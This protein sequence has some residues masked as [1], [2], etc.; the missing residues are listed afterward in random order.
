MIHDVRIIPL[1]DRP[2]IDDGIRQWHGD[3]RG[4]W[5]GDTLVVETT[6]FSDKSESP[7]PPAWLSEQVEELLAS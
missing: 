4:Y 3:A 7:A 5:D 2:H 1:D 6:N